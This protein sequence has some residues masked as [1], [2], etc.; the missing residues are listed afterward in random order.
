MASTAGLCC[1]S[2]IRSIGILSAFTDGFHNPSFKL[3]SMSTVGAS[4]G[5]SK[6]YVNRM[7][8]RDSKLPETAS[9]IVVTVVHIPE[10]ER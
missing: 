10:S 9:R 3:R 8:E 7:D 4:E 2:L 6:V 1:L 5:G